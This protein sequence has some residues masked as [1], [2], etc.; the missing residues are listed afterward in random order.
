MT[1]TDR[2]GD[3][4]AVAQSLR[5]LA[6][7]PKPAQPRIEEIAEETR[8]IRTIVQATG[9][10]LHGLGAQISDLGP[11]YATRVKNPRA[12]A[13]QI[14]GARQVIANVLA[15]VPAMAGAL[16]V[17]EVAL[18]R[19]EPSPVLDVAQ[20][21]ADHLESNPA[22]REALGGPGRVHVLGAEVDLFDEL[23]KMKAPGEDDDV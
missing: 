18:S 20:V 17:A 8:S 19:I 12:A 14:N 11:D 3:L 15:A 5:A 9:E 7:T 2:M 4:Q 13:D 1:D 22:V 10:L 21:V 23:D 16:Q 6:D